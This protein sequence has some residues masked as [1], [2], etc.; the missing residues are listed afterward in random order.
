MDRDEIKN[1]YRHNILE[2]L[3]KSASE[4]FD[5]KT[6]GAKDCHLPQLFKFIDAYVDQWFNEKDQSNG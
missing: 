4:V 5:K 3:D 2:A 6:L 1:I